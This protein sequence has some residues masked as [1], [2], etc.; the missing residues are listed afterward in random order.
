MFQSALYANHVT[1][2]LRAEIVDLKHHID[3]AYDALGDVN[4]GV[5]LFDHIFKL[6]EKIEKLEA[7]IHRALEYQLN[8]LAPNYQKLRGRAELAEAENATL[9]TRCKVLEEALENLFKAC[10][11]ADSVEELPDQVDG[12]LL[13]AARKAAE[14]E[15]KR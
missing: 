15:E 2:Q 10:A 9:E 7:E 14:K 6:K 4:R 1:A 8:V 12:S 3:G 13:D 11:L 5:Y